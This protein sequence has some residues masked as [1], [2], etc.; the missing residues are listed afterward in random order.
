MKNW[1]RQSSSRFRNSGSVLVYV[2]WALA[3]FSVLSLGLYGVVLAKIQLANRLEAQATGYYLARAAVAYARQQIAADK[4]VPDSLYEFSP[5]KEMEL[6]EGG[7]T[8]AIVD[9]ESKININTASLDVIARLPGL[10]PES[11][12]LIFHSGLKPFSVKEELLLIEGIKEEAFEAFKD[13]ITIYSSGQV[14]INTAPVAVL[15]AL[16]LD[17]GLAEDIIRFRAGADAKEATED[18]VVFENASE[19]VTKLQEYASISGSEITSLLNLTQLGLL[20]VES[21]SFS[22]AVETKIRSRPALKVAADIDEKGI[23]E[24]KEW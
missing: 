7:F 12:G 15:C 13:F 16:G 22:V 5:R 23:K 9:Q 3:F 24:W 17:E 18:D 4:T 11:A 20:S 21:K 10:D 14:N 8:Y 6:G 19:I 1:R 2:I